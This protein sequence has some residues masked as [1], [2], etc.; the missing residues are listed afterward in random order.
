MCE[1]SIHGLYRD[2]IPLFPTNNQEVKWL[3]RF[4][5]VEVCRDAEG[6]GSSLSRW[7]GMQ[8]LVC[9]VL[10][11]SSGFTLHPGP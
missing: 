2:F 3:S 8:N 6:L 10:V 4:V 7:V 9:R 11:E 1:Y 5:D